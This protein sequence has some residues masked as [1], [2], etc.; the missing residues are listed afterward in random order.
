MQALHII[1]IMVHINETKYYLQFY[2]YV[3]LQKIKT[4]IDIN[5]GLNLFVFERNK[6][7]LRSLA[8]ESNGTAGC[9]KN[10]CSLKCSYP[11]HYE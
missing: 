2:Q 9:L 5:N 10:C 6:R 8:R 1:I 3:I 4:V 11:P 7:F